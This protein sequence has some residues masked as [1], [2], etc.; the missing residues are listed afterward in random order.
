VG[1]RLEQADYNPQLQEQLSD[2]TSAALDK[3]VHA[4]KTVVP[5]IQKIDEQDI[6]SYRPEDQE[7][8]GLILSSEPSL[9]DV[10]LRNSD[11]TWYQGRTTMRKVFPVDSY[12]FQLKRDHCRDT[13][14]TV[15]LERGENPVAM[16]VR[17]DCQ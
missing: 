2:Q 4:L 1:P 5:G 8:R 3:H 13:E 6:A 14:I 16:T 12:T 15:P 11:H 7:Y 9:A 17:L 10:Y